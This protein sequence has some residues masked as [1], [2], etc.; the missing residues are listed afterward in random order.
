M[1]EVPDKAEVSKDGLNLGE[2]NRVLFQKLEE[3]TLYAISKDKTE[4][5]L[6]SKIAEL[7]NAQRVQAKILAQQAVTLKAIEKQLKL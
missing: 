4:R 2:M 7:K 3:L 5:L 1:P 6:Q